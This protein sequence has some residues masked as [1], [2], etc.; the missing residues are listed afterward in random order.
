MSDHPFL[1]KKMEGAKGLTQEHLTA[2]KQNS[3]V[4]LGRDKK[5]ILH[6]EQ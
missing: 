4:Y 3:T 2:L 1:L 6:F 5:E